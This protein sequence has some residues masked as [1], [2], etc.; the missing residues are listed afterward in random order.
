MDV[1][2]N[3]DRTIGADFDKGLATLKERAEA[4]APAGST[5]TPTPQ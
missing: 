3:T 1:F 4:A 5:A 2:M